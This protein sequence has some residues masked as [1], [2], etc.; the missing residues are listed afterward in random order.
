MLPLIAQ[1]REKIDALCGE[2][3]V[4]RLDVFGSAAKGR[5]DAERSDLDFL[6]EF[7]DLRIE[8]A[9]DRYFGLLLALADLFQ[10]RVDLVTA[11]SIR[12]PYFLK[13]VNQTRVPLYAA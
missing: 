7:E 2:Y 6:V 11:T 1:H 3:R 12:N 10:R 9:A 8:D 4:R 13:S 5:F